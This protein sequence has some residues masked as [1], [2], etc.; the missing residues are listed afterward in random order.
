MRT[1]VVVMVSIILLA[2]VC[3]AGDKEELTLKFEKAILALQL[4]QSLFVQKMADDPAVIK[5]KADLNDVGREIDSKGF[6]V[7]QNANGSIEVVK[8]APDKPKEAP[9]K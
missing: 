9:K 6:T 4:A 7:Q 3:Y 1:L 5:A 2:G 8:K